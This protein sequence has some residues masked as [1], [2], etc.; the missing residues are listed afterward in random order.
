MPFDGL[1][2]TARLVDNDS[3]LILTTSVYKGDNYI[4]PSVK[5]C[6]SHRIPPFSLSPLP[7]FL[8]VDESHF[9]VNLNYLGRKD[10][11]SRHQ[12]KEIIEE[13]GGMAE[14]WRLYLDENDKNDLIYVKV[15]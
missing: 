10:S 12:L 8:T 1:N 14:K 6:V 3:K 7:T 11:L 5:Q 15:K 2:I 13:F 9:Q 4:P